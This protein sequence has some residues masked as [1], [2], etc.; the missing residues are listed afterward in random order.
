VDA[1]PRA[2]RDPAPGGALRIL[3]ANLRNG[4]ADPE[5][6][7]DLVRETGAEVVAVQELAPAQADALARVLGHG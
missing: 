1:R 2:A 5:A 3:S 4:G 7:A 6:F